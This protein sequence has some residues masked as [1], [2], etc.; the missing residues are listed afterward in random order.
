[1]KPELVGSSQFTRYA[2]QHDG[3]YWGGE[4]WV[5]MKAKAILYAD[6]KLVEMAMIQLDARLH[7]DQQLV[8]FTLPLQISL[9]VKTGTDMDELR[10]YI[11]ASTKAVIDAE[12]VPPQGCHVLD[13]AFLWKE[14]SGPGSEVV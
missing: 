14:M 12:I 6:R 5:R 1:M 10:K 7:S 9:I 11:V 8:C 3:R 13:A 4:G 2:I